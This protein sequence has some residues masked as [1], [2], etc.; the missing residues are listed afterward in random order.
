MDGLRAHE[1]QAL[2]VLDKEVKSIKSEVSSSPFE[3]P[4]GKEERREGKGP[5]HI[6]QGEHRIGQD[7]K[8]LIKL[9]SVKKKILFS[10]V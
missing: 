7:T 4:Q 5:Q 8:I 2:L 1:S 6:S 10:W 3:L 9:R